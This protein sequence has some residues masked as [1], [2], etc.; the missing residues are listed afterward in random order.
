MFQYCKN[1]I[2]IDLSNFKT[3]NVT[4]MEG[5]FSWCTSL[6]SINLSNY[7]GSSVTTV[8]EMFLNV[9]H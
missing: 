6:I 3:N 7:D 9:H 5:M 4:T 2:E 8:E 1:I